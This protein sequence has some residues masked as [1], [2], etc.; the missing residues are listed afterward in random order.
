MRLICDAFLSRTASLGAPGVEVEDWPEPAYVG[1]RLRLDAAVV[2]AR[3]SKS[4]PDTG[5]VGFAFALRNQRDAC[6]LRQNNV[7]LVG[8]RVGEGVW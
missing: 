6:V 1:D 8:R 4:R 2:S 7:I 5:L 3:A